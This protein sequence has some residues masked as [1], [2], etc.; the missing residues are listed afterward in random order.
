MAEHPTVTT[1]F[2]DIAVDER[3]QETIASRCESFA[4]EFHEVLRIEVT[5]AEDGT[6]Y[7]VN[8]HVTCK[9]RGVEAQAEASELAPAADRLLDKIERQLRTLHDKRIFSQRREARR[10][11]PKKRGSEA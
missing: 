5:L 2:K 10:D 11:P 7:A 9:G 1:K 8:G 4:R 6:G 3:I